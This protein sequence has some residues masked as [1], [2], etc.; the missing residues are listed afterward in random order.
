MISCLLQQASIAASRN[1][2]FLIYEENKYSPGGFFFS[3]MNEIIQVINHFMI[4]TINN[5]NSYIITCL[6]EK[7]KARRFIDGNEIVIELLTASVLLEL[8]VLLNYVQKC[9]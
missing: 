5:N 7:S 3:H 1:S 6:L 4:F 8:L 2:N 9:F